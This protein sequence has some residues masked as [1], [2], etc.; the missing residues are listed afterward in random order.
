MIVPNNE[1]L[2]KFKET[3]GAFSVSESIA[4]MN[5]ASTVPDGYNFI[6]AGT[7]AGKSSM[8]AAYGLPEG[9]F[10][11]ID[12]IFDLNNIEA[13]RHT[14]QG[15]PDNMPWGYVKQNGF[16]EKV[17]ERV[18]FASDG[19]VHPVLLGSYSEAELPRYGKYSFVFIDSDNHQRERVFAEIAII[20]DMVVEGGIVA[21]HDFGN[22]YHAPM[23]AH[24]WLI[25]T[26]KYE[27]VPIN[28]NEIFDYVRANNLEEGNDT[29][30]ERGSNEFPCYVGAVRRKV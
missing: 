2:K 27:N 30:H 15:Y 17:K 10:Y 26:G 24:A 21:F 13:W 25:S 6:E 23:E 16:N 20:E 5:I 12:P 1:F 11:L 8:S 28:W 3:Q 18:R 14:I 4:L 29:W 22:Q 7:N 19:L 9:V